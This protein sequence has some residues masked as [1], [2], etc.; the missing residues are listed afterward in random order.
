MECVEYKPPDAG[1]TEFPP[2]CPF[3]PIGR[4]YLSHSLG[5]EVMSCLSAYFKRGV[6]LTARKCT[7]AALHLN[8]VKIANLSVPVCAILQPF[9]WS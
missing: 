8:G 4:I 1:T 3:P 6:I 9:A 5:V 7:H 2:D